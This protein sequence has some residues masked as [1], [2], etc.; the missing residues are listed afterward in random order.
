[1]KLYEVTEPSHPDRQPSNTD[2]V[3]FFTDVGK[4]CGPFLQQ[5]E[6]RW[7][8]MYRGVTIAT[9]PLIEKKARLSNRVPLET[10]Q[11]THDEINEIFQAKFGHPFRNG[12][13]ASGNLSLVSTYGITFETFPIGQFKFLWSPD[14]PDLYDTM[15]ELN[16][17]SANELDQFEYRTNDLQAAIDSKNEIMVWCSGY[18]GAE[19]QYMTQL[20]VSTENKTF[21]QFYGELTAHYAKE[22]QTK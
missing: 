18:L 15:E 21:D 11:T 12:V 20:P 3:A 16:I 17:K 2:I 5:A 8:N 7:A 10:S 1:M 9:S 22:S 4:R 13:F 19:V 14:V 6:T